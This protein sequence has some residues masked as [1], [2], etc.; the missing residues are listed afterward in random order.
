MDLETDILS[1]SETDENVIAELL[2]ETLGKD[3]LFSHP[4]GTYYF[5]K[6]WRNLGRQELQ[7]KVRTGLAKINQTKKKMGFK[8]EK[9]TFNKV[10]SVSEL[11][12]MAC[13]REEVNFNSGPR[14]VLPV[15]NGDL[16]FDGEKWSLHDPVREH[17]RVTRSPVHYDPHAKAEL[18]PGFL[19]SIFEGDPDAAEKGNLVLKMMGLA[20]MTDTRFERF[21]LCI[22]LGANGKSVLFK[23]IR[24]LVGHLNTSAVH[25]T[26]F[27]STF[28]RQHIDGKLVNIVSENQQGDKLPTADV[29]ALVSGDP[30]TVERKHHDP[31]VMTPYATL[32]WGTNHLPHPSDYS[33]ALYRR[34]FI[35]SFN[36]SF[37]GREDH[38]LENKLT[39]ELSGILNMIM[40]QLAG[41]ITTGDFDEPE[42]S[43][44]LRER[45][46]VEGDQA[47][48]WL[49]QRTEPDLVA[50]ILITEAF[51]DYKNWSKDQGYQ[52]TMARNSFNLRLEAA[53]VEKVRK[54]QGMGWKG[55]RLLK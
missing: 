52:G 44:R 54:N 40:P 11:I 24:A 7:N 26:Q 10:K 53:G 4:T 1:I 22:G 15:A 12:K 29:K 51:E 20:L 2:I 5:E 41:L 42:S 34:T 45:W 39:Q 50:H 17:H 13:F 38:E 47:R 31:Y 14:D 23:V 8:P 30:M 43:S 49:E 33:N 6:N 35:L 9:V 46:R 27:G 16:L 18:F 32:F 48:L 36:Q 37:E 21:L 25:P 28:H 55:R 3:N 19:D